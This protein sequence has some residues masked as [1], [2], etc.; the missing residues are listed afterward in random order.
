MVVDFKNFA[1]GASLPDEGILW[2]AEQIPGFV[3]RNDMTKRLKENSYWASYNIPYSQ[4]IYDVSGYAEA[5]AQQGTFWSHN[6]YARAEIFRRNQQTVATIGDVQRLMR[7]NNYTMDP[8]ALIPNCSGAANGGTCSPAYSSMLAVASRGDLMPVYNTTAANIAHYG[9]LYGYMAQGCFGAI[10]AK[11]AR[12][13]DRHTLS[14]RVISGP[15]SDGG[16]PPFAWGTNGCGAAPA[17]PTV[18]DFPWVEFFI[19]AASCNA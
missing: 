11:I 8:F 19:G 12:Y 13:S 2:I 15:T 1:P 3:Y 10:D 6:Q 18:V 9:P 4:Y 7:L 5:L 17:G 16:L 14:A